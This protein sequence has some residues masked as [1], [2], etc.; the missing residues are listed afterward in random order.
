MNRQRRADLSSIELQMLSICTAAFYRQRSGNPQ[1]LSRQSA[2]R[3]SR[4]QPPA[5]LH[6][7]AQLH[8]DR[9]LKMQD[10]KGQ[11]NPGLAV[12]SQPRPLSTSRLESGLLPAAPRAFVSRCA[13]IFRL[14]LITAG[15]GSK[16]SLL[17]PNANSPAVHRAKDWP[18]KSRVRSLSLQ[19]VPTHSQDANSAKQLLDG[20]RRCRSDPSWEQIHP[21]VSA[22]EHYSPNNLSKS[23]SY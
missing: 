19:A 22:F 6:A 11:Q 3:R 13:S 12:V 15:I 1:A 9:T 7:S 20:A 2:Y 21:E 23:K 18:H 16:A 10:G 8:A 17:R 14:V 4:L 5:G